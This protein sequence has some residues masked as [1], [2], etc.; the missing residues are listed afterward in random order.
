MNLGR[1][2]IG[3]AVLATLGGCTSSGTTGTTAKP[4]PTANPCQA[5]VKPF[6]SPLIEASPRGAKAAHAVTSTAPLRCDTVLSVTE[7]GAVRIIFGTTTRCLLL[8][9]TS[10]SGVLLTGV[11]MKAFFTLGMGEVL[12]SSTTM[13]NKS[14]SI[15]NSGVLYLNGPSQWQATCT[16]SLIFEVTV[17]TGSVRLKYPT[18]SLILRPYQRTSFDFRTRKATPPTPVG[19]SAAENSLF[20]KL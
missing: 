18:G 17:K 3:L 16:P 14:F 6:D 19:I 9:G 1:I 20:A 4:R 7:Q 12:C 2:L 10:A 13:P 15:C 5:S 11:P 8:R